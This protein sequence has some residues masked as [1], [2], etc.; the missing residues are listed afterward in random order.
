MIRTKL[1]SILDFVS[2][3]IQKQIHALTSDSIQIHVPISDS[4]TNPRAHKRFMDK[5][6]RSQAI[7]MQIHAS[8]A[9]KRSRGK[10]TRPQAIQM[11][12]NAPVSDLNCLNI[13]QFALYM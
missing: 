4:L 8:L 12:I 3:A 2:K 13:V 9:N 6:T 11:Q 10:S 1:R 5:S 7:Q